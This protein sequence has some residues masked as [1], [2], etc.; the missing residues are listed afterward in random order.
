[1]IKWE[2]IY[3]KLITERS[4]CI[5]PYYSHHIIPKHWIKPLIWTNTEDRYCRINLSYRDHILAHYIL[6]RWCK[7][8]GD[9]YMYC[10][11]LGTKYHIMHDPEFLNSEKYKQRNEKI[12]KYRATQVFSQESNIKRALA[13]KETKKLHPQKHT[14]QWKIDQSERLKEQYRTGNRKVINKGQKLSKE[15]L[16]K[17]SETMKQNYKT[18]KRKPAMLGKHHT[19]E[20]KRKISERSKLL[21]KPVCQ[22]DLQGNF[23]NEF[24]SVAE[25][26][27]HMKQ[28][29]ISAT[30]GNCAK[31]Q[32]GTA[33]GYIWLYK[34]DIY[35]GF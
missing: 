23:I 26:I 6:Y 5:K 31:R 7:S 21:G 9:K 29:N 4:S 12:K 19:E 30:V 35:C 24:I 13:T 28:H 17:R 3:N 18:G 2:Q 25:A 20:A 15:T 14:E 10:R 27:R 11:S 8:L 32:S 1:M 34:E 16:R 22:F 33:G